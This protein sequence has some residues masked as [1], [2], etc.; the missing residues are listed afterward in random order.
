MRIVLAHGGDLSVP[1]GGH[2]RIVAFASGLADHGHEVAVVAPTPGASLPERLDGV[3]VRPVD[4]PTNGVRTQPRRGIAVTRAARRLANQWEAR[5]QV[6]HSPLGGV[7][8]VLGGEGYVL[9]MHDVAFASPFYRDRPLG[10]VLSRGI[11]WVEGRGLRSAGDVV[12]VSERMASFVAETWDV[13]P[14]AI[15]VVPN[16]YF[17]TDVAGV[18]PE[19]HD[20]TRVVFVGTLH[21]KLD[22]EAVV[23]C[24][25]LSEVDDL[26]VVGDGPM[27]A[28]LARAK[29]ERGVDS[30]S[31]PGRLSTRRTW[32]LVAGADVAIN[33]QRQSPTQAVSSPVKLCYYRALGVPMVL[34]DGPDLARTFADEG[35]AFLVGPDEDF[36]ARLAALLSDETALQAARSRIRSTPSG[37]TWADRA[38]TL[39]RVYE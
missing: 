31:L 12:V 34:S 4:V 3:D 10:T 27:R 19:T 9:D 28:E 30:L 6:E 24:A 25:G 14:E 33:P 16:G 11:R 32:S 7:T 20:G 36:A 1:S 35:V 22:F 8:S 26:L 2:E 5:L 29:R 17:E 13:S 18:E 15:T 23:D 21:P 38:E 37:P 39:C